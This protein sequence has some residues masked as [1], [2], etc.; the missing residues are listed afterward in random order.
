MAICGI[1]AIYQ[2]P[3]GALRYGIFQGVSMATTTGFASVDFSLWPFMLPVLLIFASFV[4]ACAGSTGGGIKV[5]R[6]LL[7]FKLAMKE[8]KHE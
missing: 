5:V 6:V 3:E 1:L 7:M 2:T 4:G 8:I